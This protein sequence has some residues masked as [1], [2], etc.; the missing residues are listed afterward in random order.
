MSEPG[1]SA[2]PLA[3][4]TQACAP[5]ILCVDDE[6][7]ILS[8]LRRL[9]RTRGYKVLTAESGAAGLELLRSEAVDLVISDMRMPGMDGAQF[10][11]QVRS[12]WPDT[13]RLLLTGYAD[14]AAIIEA[15]N[16][17]EI[18]RYVTKP[19]DD[20]D[21]VLV[22]RHALERRSLEIEKE[23]LEVLTRS[24]N[25]ELK[26][27]NASL[28]AKVTE[29]TLALQSANGALEVANSR[30]KGS[31]IT[32]IKVFSSL[33]E[34]R[35]GNL[36]GHSRRVADLA[37]KIAQKMELDGRQLQ[38]IF[39]AGLLCDIGKVGF[40]DEL[41]AVPVAQMN[42]RQLE[43]FRRHTELAEQLLLPLEDLR[44][45]ALIIGA[46]LERFDGAGFPQRLA[47]EQIP[48]GARI[49]TVASD[50]DSLQSGTL[51]PR[52][53]PAE[54][55]RG[56]IVQSSG[57]RYD[58]QVVACFSKCFAADAAGSRDAAA[59]ALQVAAGDLV[60]GMV[61]ARDLISPQG[62]LMLSAEHVLDRRM[63]QKILDFQ[64]SG[65]EP[66]YAQVRPDRAVPRS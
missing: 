41:M 17:G 10:L 44:T 50:Y 7:N 63:I 56:V 29:R 48:V 32:S 11:E 66:L 43:Q 39:V 25:D 31:F 16:K 21:I 5:T 65:G 36:A 3:G 28:E 59:T 6:P 47:G 14:V 35:G 51:V 34:M 9:F 33:I 40:A 15:I 46:Q 61:L 64:R 13:V 49:L 1:P 2:V 37:R 62:V 23:R 53:L 20:N 27:L 26:A 60:A 12:T 57:K 58:P 18:Y 54:E 55:A 22:V 24:Q 8:A 19:W 4:V 45:A 52:R 30:L 38:D 42:T